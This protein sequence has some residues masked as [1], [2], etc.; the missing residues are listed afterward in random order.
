MS[1]LKLLSFLQSLDG[2][3]VHDVGVLIAHGVPEP[4]ATIG[5]NKF[6]KVSDAC[7]L[8]AIGTVLD[9]APDGVVVRG[10]Y[11][12]ALKSIGWFAAVEMLRQDVYTKRGAQ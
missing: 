10:Y 2:G 4:V 3:G 1:T 7:L 5:K 12:D 6:G 8:D 11:I 9:A